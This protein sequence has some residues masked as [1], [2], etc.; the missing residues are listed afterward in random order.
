[1]GEGEQVAIYHE[2]DGTVEHLLKVA[3]H[4]EVL[5]SHLGAWHEGDEDIDIAVGT[6]LATRT[7]TEE[8]CLLDGLRLEV[9]A[10][11][12]S[13]LSIAH[14]IYLLTTDCSD[15]RGCLLLFLGLSEGR[16][17]AYIYVYTVREKCEIGAKL[18]IF[19]VIAKFFD[20]F[21]RLRGDY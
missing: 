13:Y 15:G 5:E 10:Y 21:F 19:S 20:I 17:C 11:A 2:I 6:F 4:T 18:L 1:M 8:P 9:L 12:M 16:M 14:F 3:Y 7:A